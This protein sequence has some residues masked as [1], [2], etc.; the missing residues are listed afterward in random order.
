MP[1]LQKVRSPEQHGAQSEATK[2]EAGEA[3]S[4]VQRRDF[5]DMP[6]VE[7]MEEPI[8]TPR[9][10]VDRLAPPPVPQGKLSRIDVLELD[11][12]DIFQIALFLLRPVKV[13]ELLPLCLTIDRSRL[14]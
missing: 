13:E 1:G 7:D 8:P 9:R 11:I 6:D 14:P 3:K 10:S 2:E 5:E 4:V 12:F